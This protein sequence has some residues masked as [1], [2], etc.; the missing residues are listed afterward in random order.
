MAESSGIA[1]RTDP[2]MPLELSL[3]AGLD[4]YDI[5]MK[6]MDPLVMAA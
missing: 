1:G 6:R 2:N 4:L 3:E 5:K